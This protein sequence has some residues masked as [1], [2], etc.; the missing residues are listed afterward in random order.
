MVK[1]KCACVRACVR[2]CACV[3][4]CSSLATAGGCCCMAALRVLHQHRIEESGTRE[5]PSTIKH[6]RAVFGS[7][8]FCPA[9]M[10]ESE[11][12]LGSQCQALCRPRWQD[13]S[14]T[15]RKLA[16]LYGSSRDLTGQRRC[17][18]GAVGE[19][20][21]DVHHH[22]RRHRESGDRVE[23]RRGVPDLG[24]PDQLRVWLDV[25]VPVV[26]RVPRR[27]VVADV[28][29]RFGPERRL[30]RRLELQRG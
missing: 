12:L 24:R 26:L 2:A 22:R 27:V 11:N 7:L 8:A 15:W 29:D 21:V 10:L 5:T 30:R 16:C 1:C 9:T 4:V 20:G 28:P 13:R 18:L 25:L 3:R 23:G 17:H 19:D 6:P 14:S